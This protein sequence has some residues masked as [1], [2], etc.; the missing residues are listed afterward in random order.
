LNYK[1]FRDEFELQLRNDSK[2]NL[3]IDKQKIYEERNMQMDLSILFTKKEKQIIKR[4]IDD[5]AIS[6]TDYEYYSRK[7]KKKIKSI[8]GLHEFALS[9]YSKTP[10]YDEELYLLK[11][12]LED[13]IEGDSKILDFFLSEGNIFIN[14]TNW[15]SESH[16][17]LKLSQIKDSKTLELI[18]KY[19]NH[20]FR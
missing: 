19:K 2:P 6:R 13:R 7:T 9:F 8:L 3:L 16:K 4:M 12:E 10:K 1:E 14:F 5:K 20:D 17:E 18:K 11:R 15:G